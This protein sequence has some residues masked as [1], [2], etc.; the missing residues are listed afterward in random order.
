MSD[1]I[2]FWC[3]TNPY[4]PSG[5]PEVLR[6]IIKE[7]DPEQVIYR[8]DNDAANKV[9]FN[10]PLNIKDF[11]WIDRFFMRFLW[12]VE[13]A[14]RLW[15][16]TP[17]LFLLG[18][19]TII[20]NR[21]RKIVT[22][23]FSV[24]WILSARLLSFFTGK[25]LIYYAHDPFKEKYLSKGAS[26]RWAVG[27]IEKMTIKSAK[28]VVLYH[29]IGKLYSNEYGVDY[30]LLPHIISP[31]AE[32]N[33]KW[34]SSDRN[35]TIAFAGSIYDNN[36]DLVASLVDY[37]ARSPI[38][39]IKFYGNISESFKKEVIGELHHKVEFGFE[40]SYEALIAKL[41]QSDILYLPL[42]F[43]GTKD[44]PRECLKY[45]IP[46]KAID[47][48]NTKRPILVHCPKDYAMYDFMSQF[49][50]VQWIEDFDND[51]LA[52][53]IDDAEGIYKNNLKNFAIPPEHKES[54]FKSQLREILNYD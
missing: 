15:I 2:L 4:H 24:E 54:F 51:H 41:T 42:S 21:P 12:R 47:Y 43:T 1:K 17:I 9:S 6:R 32:E 7:I 50:H 16:K 25:D 13:F 35:K 39:Q 48:L 44:L 22:I 10:Y 5:S 49:N 28:L 34:I 29:S 18:L 36:K 40:S 8:C 45:V 46:T 52:Q 23:Y 53:F 20:K 3:K 11:G 38:L 30:T 14:Y 19:G 37:V 31:I 26:A 33:D 27:L